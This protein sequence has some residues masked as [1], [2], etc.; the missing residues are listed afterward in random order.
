MSM[1]QR[2][3][4]IAEDY[5]DVSDATY[6]Y[7]DGLTVDELRVELFP[8]ARQSMRILMRD[9]VR[10]VEDEVWGDADDGDELFTPTPKRL[11][12]LIGK[13]FALPDGRFVHW[14][15]ATADEHRLRAD[16][17]R[18]NAAGCA[19]SAERHEHAAEMIEAAGALCLADIK[20]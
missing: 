19:K 14:L 16:M 13:R 17:Q 15:T 9:E 20:E 10:G 7:I 2:M 3:R 8:H 12:K 1:Y 4:A 6:A 18:R 11:E 5:T